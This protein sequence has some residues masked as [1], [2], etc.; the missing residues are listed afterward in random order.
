MGSTEVY[1]AGEAVLV[2]TGSGLYRLAANSLGEG[3]QVTNIPI[4]RKE[5]SYQKYIYTV[6]EALFVSTA[7]GLYRI[8]GIHDKKWSNPI[9]YVGGEDP[10]PLLCGA[11][12]T[13]PMD[14]Y[15][16][17]ISNRLRGRNLSCVCGAT[18]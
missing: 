2:A 11:S 4:P 5:D 8:E 10:T 9:R 15:S 12:S 3:Q 14:L 18:N 6:D 17:A 16:C 7:E 1:R 13:T